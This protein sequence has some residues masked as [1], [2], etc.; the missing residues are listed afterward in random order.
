MHS[1]RPNA[2]R[3]S[4]FSIVELMISITIGLMLLAGL[5]T[6][7]VNSSDS[8]REARRASQQIENG[9]YAIDTLSQD[10]RLAGYLGAFRKYTAPTSLPDAC[11]TAT[12]SLLTAISLPVQGY[13][14]ATT[15]SQPSP[16][17]SCSTWLSSVN[18]RAG[19]DILVVR[20]AD[21]TAIVPGAATTSGEVYLQANP[22][23]AAVQLGGGTTTCISDAIGTAAT[24]SRRCVQ[25][26][27]S[28]ACPTECAAGTAPAGEI[29][30]LRVH[31]YFVAPCSLP[32]NG[33]DICTGSTDDGGTPIP[34][35]KRLEITA[36][37]G[38]VTFKVF[39]IAEGVE[40]MKV[41]YGIDD[42]PTAV[43]SDTGL[44]G[45]GSPDRDSVSPT[46]ADFSNA[47]TV[48]VDLLMRNS[49]KSQGY[50]DFKTY[51]LGVDPAT[52]TNPYVSVG[53]FSDGYRRHVYASEVRLVNLSS[54][55]E[56]P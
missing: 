46:V 47:V 28:D 3:Q 5:V 44:V 54:R 8:E 53:P 23:T 17:S 37:S 11:D 49:Q 32:A 38:A 24:I 40:Y 29:R 42:T 36:V 21:T 45:D 12:A 41:E 25:P 55:K 15:S 30:K 14:A 26:A 51:N 2:F 10:V 34:T 4:G 31:L 43:N 27:A 1:R 19:S 7:F 50:V 6:L 39:P 52:P 33:S 35:L 9:R 56:N 18:L 20:R 48:R 13:Q 22:A 16:P